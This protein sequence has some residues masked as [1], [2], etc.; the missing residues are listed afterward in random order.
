MIKNYFLALIGGQLFALGKDSVAGIGIHNDSRAKLL[1]DKGRKFLP[2]PDGNQ[3]IF[4]DLQQVMPGGES[5]R[6]KQS[7]YLIVT[8][9]GQY[10][11]LL[12][13][14]KGRLFM[15]DETKQCSLPPALT[16]VARELISGVLVNC[17]DLI[18]LL[19]APSLLKAPEWVASGQCC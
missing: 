9:E 11:A 19:N 1:E 6:S 14:G 16:G 12:M 13:T 15:A 2:L 17:H 5:R 8:H 10:V 3:A 4:C 18:L 7:H